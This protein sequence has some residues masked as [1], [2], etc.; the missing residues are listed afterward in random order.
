M[1]TAHISSNQWQQPDAAFASPNSVWNV[2]GSPSNGFCTT[3]LLSN[4]STTE[5]KNE[6]PNATQTTAAVQPPAKP[7]KKRIRRQKLELEYLRKLVLNL[8][9][10]RSGLKA[11]QLS[12]YKN[13]EGA[14]ETDVKAPPI[15]KEIA[16]RQL[17]ER[18][19]VGGT[20]RNLRSS[21]EGQIKLAEKLESMLRTRPRDEAAALLGDAKRF[22]PSIRASLSPTD[23]EIFADQLAH[24]QRAHL[25]VDRLFGG[26]EFANASSSFCDLHVTNDSKTDTGV[27]F[28][29]KASSML[30]F[31][32]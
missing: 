28:V 24:V 25:Q 1:N 29:K 2:G 7:K 13:S 18:I 3:D 16:E 15:W 8:E 4:V 32:L 5:S 6:N 17:K 11:K 12:M 9:E 21:L 30:P 22:R 23:D 10:Q 27:A 31:N 14:A 19:R 26:Q 20:N